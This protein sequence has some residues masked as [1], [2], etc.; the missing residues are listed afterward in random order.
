MV[1]GG[2]LTAALPVA[3]TVGLK[4]GLIPAGKTVAY[5]GGKAMRAID[6][7]VFNPLS[8]IIGSET[9]GGGAK[10]TME[11]LGNQSTK[12]RQKLNIPDPKDWKFYPTDSNAPLT[13]TV[14][15]SPPNHWG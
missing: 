8:K 11:F 9:V 4:Y 13:P 3:G 5:A 1:L 15:S 14:T 6:Y 12:L 10:T 7:T 2:G